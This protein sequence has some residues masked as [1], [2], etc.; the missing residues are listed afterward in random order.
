MSESDDTKVAVELTAREVGHVLAG[1]HLVVLALKHALRGVA[2]ADIVEICTDRGLHRLLDDAGIDELRERL[3]SAPQALLPKEVAERLHHWGDKDAPFSDFEDAFLCA[4]DLDGLGFG[5]RY[6][7]DPETRKAYQAWLK[8]EIEEVEPPDEDTCPECGGDLA[9]AT[10]IPDDAICEACGWSKSGV[11]R[12]IRCGGKDG[13]EPDD[14]VCRRCRAP[15]PAK[16]RG[17]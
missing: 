8:L 14:A 7:Y 13:L 9:D 2:W 16:E 15:G 11:R 6:F 4:H 10:D 3:K 1:L 5:E 17:G 12:C